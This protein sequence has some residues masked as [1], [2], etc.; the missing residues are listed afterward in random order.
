MLPSRSLPDTPLVAA[1]RE[2]VAVQEL[3]MCRFLLVQAGGRMTDSSFP[4]AQNSCLC[5]S[6]ILPIPP[7]SETTVPGSCFFLAEI[8]M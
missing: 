4:P 3:P 1:E 8:L 6:P 2:D 7:H 5:P